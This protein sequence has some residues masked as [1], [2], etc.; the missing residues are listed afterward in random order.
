MGSSLPAQGRIQPQQTL[1]EGQQSCPPP[2]IPP[3]L[4]PGSSSPLR[5]SGCLCFCCSC[6]ALAPVGI[7]PEHRAAAAPQVKAQH[8]PCC[9]PSWARDR[10]AHRFH[11]AHAVPTC[12]QPLDAADPSAGLVH[13]QGRGGSPSKRAKWKLRAESKG[14]SSFRAGLYR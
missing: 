12:T 4:P 1:P 8:L 9:S 11:L 6:G 14:F 5:S 10:T 13:P 2:A 3:V 7:S